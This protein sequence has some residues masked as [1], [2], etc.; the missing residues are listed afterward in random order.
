MSFARIMLIASIA[1]FGFIGFKA[2]SKKKGELQ[3]NETTS[4]LLVPEDKSK[5]VLLKPIEV[6][7]G[8]TYLMKHDPS[9]AIQT[10]KKVQEDDH[11]E[12]VD[13]IGQLFSTGRDKLPI[14]ETVTYSS[15]VSWI[16]GR[17]AWVAD[18]ASHYATSRHFIARSLNG[19]EDYITQKVSTGDRFNVLRTDKNI[20]FYLLVDI[21]R[22][23]M[24]FYYLDLEQNEK[25]LL[26]TYRIG[27]GRLEQNGESLTP[28]GRYLLG[29]KVATY[30]PGTVGTFQNKAIEMIQVFGTRWLPFKEEIGDCSKA[31]KGYGIHGAPCVLDPE[32][33]DIK[34][35]REC[36]GQYDSDGCIRLYKEDVEEIF[37]IVI[38]RPTIVEVVKDS[39][40]LREEKIENLQIITHELQE[41]H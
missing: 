37:S 34:E 3:K 32:T 6:E 15:R 14:V 29:D 1:V 22:L 9:K 13:R 2:Y 30:K 4:R 31:A 40:K 33:K 12:K 27:V 28:T 10:A 38:T 18:Y 25:V 41:R 24:W 26:K 7:S 5:D 8:H 39:S 20:N 17:P 36:I 19:K 11:D 35:I 21:S 16:K 23:K